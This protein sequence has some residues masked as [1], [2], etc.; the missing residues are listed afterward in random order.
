MS[1]VLRIALVG[2]P[3]CGKT[4]LFNQLT[5][6]KQ[7]VGNYAGVTVERKEGHFQ[8]PSGQ[9]VRVLDLPGTYSLNAASLDEDVTRRVCLGEVPEEVHQDAFLL[10]ADATN[11]KLN[12]KLVLEMIALKRPVLLILNMM[13]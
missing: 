6:T 5:G 7:K 1:E 12:L 9:A 3:N 2:N 13:D 10:V 4:S 11:L 8:L